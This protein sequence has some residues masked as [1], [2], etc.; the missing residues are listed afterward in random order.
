MQIGLSNI[1]T[2][3]AVSVSYDDNHGTVST[4]GVLCIDVTKNDKNR[5]RWTVMNK[6]KQIQFS[7]D[8]SMRTDSEASKTP[9]SSWEGGKIPKEVIAW[10]ELGHWFC[11]L[12]LMRKRRMRHA[13]RIYSQDI[14]MAFSI[15]KCV[16]L[17]MKS[18]KR[19]LTDGMEL[20]N[21]DKIR[22]LADNEIYKYLG[23]FEDDSI[24]QVEMKNKNSQRI[25]LKN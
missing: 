15:E 5:G 24:K 22:T 6:I 21:Q 1:W 16:M 23:I 3:V 18:G 17:V 14:G 19:H 7:A 9:Q 4:S 25:S 10:D 20:P 11:S 13:V 12:S 2:R 8:K